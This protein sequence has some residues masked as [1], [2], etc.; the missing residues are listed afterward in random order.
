MGKTA[1][2]KVKGQTSTFA[3]HRMGCHTEGQA[4]YAFDG[5]EPKK[6]FTNIPREDAFAPA[7]LRA[8]TDIEVA[9]ME[10][11]LFQT[12]VWLEQLYS[13]YRKCVTEHKQEYNNAN[14]ASEDKNAEGPCTTKRHECDKAQHD[15]EIARCWWAVDHDYHC[16]SYVNCVKQYFVD[17]YHCKTLCKDVREITA[18]NKA[19]YETGERIQCLLETL[20]GSVNPSY[21]TSTYNASD[22]KTW[23]LRPR[24]ANNT[25]LLETNKTDSDETAEWVKWC[26]G[27]DTADFSEFE[28]IRGLEPGKAV[29]DRFYTETEKLSS[30]AKTWNAPLHVLNLYNQKKKC[31]ICRYLGV[32]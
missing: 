5:R 29:L 26:H 28:R 1:Q 17:S 31:Q 6:D 21:S 18:R 24:N 27:D 10:N 22:D 13:Q 16:T 20:F 32:R 3:R 14:K 11:C 19:D 25:R 8:T 30:G 4:C 23:P 2:G 15:F 12:K 7:Y 9:E